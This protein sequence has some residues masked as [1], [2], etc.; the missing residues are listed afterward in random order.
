MKRALGQP[1]YL[2]DAEY[3]PLDRWYFTV[4]G[5]S[6]STYETVLTPI[7]MSC[8]CPDFKQR[9]KL[10]KHLYFVIA[11]VAKDT[12]TVRQ[13]NE[14][15]NVFKIKPNFSEN[16]KQRLKKRLESTEEIL[17]EESEESEIDCVICFEGMKNRHQKFSCHQCNNTFHMLCISK[18]LRNKD[19]CPLCRTKITV[20]ETQ[21]QLSNNSLEHFN[22]LVIN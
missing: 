15:I 7:E 6:G 10:C 13:I 8:T 21:I 5:Y 2:I 3:K 17:K 1:M 9:K 11:R 4:Q 16:I 22:N 18:W 19:T 20:G 14:E 12:E